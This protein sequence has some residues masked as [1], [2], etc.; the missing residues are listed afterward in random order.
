MKNIF[1]LLCAIL[2]LCISQATFAQVPKLSSYKDSIATIFIDFDG[3]TVDG[4]SW[5]GDGPI[6]CNSANLN[7]TQMTEI[8]NRVSEDYRPFNVNVTTDSTKYWNAPATQRM[9]VIL[10]TS[11]SWFGSAGGV[12]FNNS[13]TWGD[14]TPCFVF[15]ALLNYNVKFIAEATSHEVGHTLGLN[16]QSKYD[17]SCNK[18]SEYNPGSGSSTTNFGWAPIM[19]V[20]YYQNQTL[21]HYGSN[22]F[23]CSY[24]Q[25]DLGVIT[26]SNGFGYRKDDHGNTSSTA[27]TATF[28]NN[29]FAVKGIIESPEDADLI[30]FTV[31]SKNRF[32]LSALPFS[33]GADDA[34][35]D[36]DMQVS[37]LNSKQTDSIVYNPATKLSA[38]ID[39]VLDAGTYY[40]RVKGTGNA[41]A[42]GFASLGSYTLNGS[43]VQTTLPL[44][45]LELKAAAESG[46]HK[47]DWEIVADE[48]VVQQV[49]ETS[50]D[51]TTFNTLASVSAGARTFWTVPAKTNRSYYRMN[52]TFDDGRQYY[53]NIAALRSN[54]AEAR[55]S[56]LGNVVSGNLSV[57]SPAGYSY[58]VTDLNG[59][60]IAKGQLSAGLNSISTGFLTSGLY[61]LRFANNQQQYTEKFMKQ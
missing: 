38:S 4:T 54:T 44:H 59:R 55:P 3:Q 1:T 31:A 21:W 61:L 26:G 33:I 48:S 25:D 56:L 36:V 24:M 17:S 47:L 40:L 57:N 28:T 39:T 30:K 12:S 20:G 23:G 16:H 11:S 27:T 14:N 13:F 6:V 22:P 58:L 53:S 60:T 18:T 2:L 7:A 43:L 29:Q 51:G 15:T 50:T 9:R 19:G 5:N 37:L 34:G 49:V 32:Q 42:P 10:T 46:R 35:A 8:F 52:V 45:R 41:Y